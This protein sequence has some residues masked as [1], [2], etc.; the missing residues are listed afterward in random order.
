MAMTMAIIG[1]EFDLS[2]SSTFPLATLLFAAMLPTLGLPL[3]IILITLIGM[4]IDALMVFLLQLP[5]SMRLL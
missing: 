1:G 4:G 5:E 2:V 3:T